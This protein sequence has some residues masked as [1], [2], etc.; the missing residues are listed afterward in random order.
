MGTARNT[1][2]LAWDRVSSADQTNIS[3][4]A[5]AA[6]VSKMLPGEES[7]IVFPLIPLIKILF[8]EIFSFFVLVTESVLFE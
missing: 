2:W 6:L 8:H 4:D 1:G 3:N 5:A 7:D